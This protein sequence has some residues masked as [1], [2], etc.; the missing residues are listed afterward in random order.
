LGGKWLPNT[1]KTPKG[2]GTAGEDAA[3]GFLEA[4]APEHETLRRSE[5]PRED[6]FKRE[7]DGYSAARKPQ[8]PGK[9]KAEEGTKNQYGR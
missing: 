9:P 3:K 8:G 1:G 2:K 4:A 7:F 5:R 6:T